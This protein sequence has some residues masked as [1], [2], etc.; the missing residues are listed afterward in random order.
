MAGQFRRLH[1]ILDQYVYKKIASCIRIF[2]F[3]RRWNSDV[4]GLLP[5]LCLGQGKE[6]RLFEFVFIE[7][8]EEKKSI[9]GVQ[10]LQE[11]S[12]I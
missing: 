7:E 3:L 12:K 6:G 5:P 2:T 1:R 4:D 9:L 10:G 8:V 11:D